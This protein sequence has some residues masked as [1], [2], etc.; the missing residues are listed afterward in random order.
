LDV[1]WNNAAVNMRAPV[2]EVTEDSWDTGFAV[3]VKSQFFAVQRALPMMRRRGRGVVINTSALAGLQASGE[4][5]TVYTASKTA[6]VGLTKSLALD[7]GPDNIRVYCICPGAMDTP[8]PRRTLNSLPPERRE[9]A[10]ASWTGRQIQHR[11][12]SPDEVAAV[13]VFLASEDASFMT[14]TIV[15]VDGGRM[16]W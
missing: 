1:L 15:P 9:A 14:G 6:I 7:L 16:A 10:W 3:N 11:W 12:A 5:G 8:M 2:S 4:N 13:A